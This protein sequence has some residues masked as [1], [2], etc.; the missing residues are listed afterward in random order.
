MGI[1]ALND[2][3]IVVPI[4]PKEQL[5]S[6]GL[7]FIPDMA[8][9]NDK[10]SDWGTVIAVGPKVTDVHVGD[11]VWFLE[12]VHDYCGKPYHPKSLNVGDG[13]L[14]L[15]LKKSDIKLVRED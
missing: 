15:G 6:S 14:Y 13:E 10:G 1:K 7:L 2:V 12:R 3:V 5:S 11:V 9:D 8:K 4:P